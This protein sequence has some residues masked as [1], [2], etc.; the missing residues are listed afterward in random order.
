[1]ATVVVAR[2]AGAQP[3][4]QAS[5][6]ISLAEILSAL[7]FALDLTEGAVPGHALRSCLLGMRLGKELG[8]DSSRMASLYYALLLKDVGCSSNAARLCQII[9]GGDERRVK[10][11]VK[12]EDWTQPSKPKASTFKLLW[13]TVLPNGN[14]IERAAAIAHIGLTQHRNNK[15]IITLR[16]DRGAHILRK[17]GL[18]DIAAEAVRGL[19]EHWDG[20]GY[21]DSRT[22][23]DIPIESR[24]LAVAQHL[25]VFAT[26]EG[27]GK[28]I[29]VLR[30]RSGRWYDPEIVRIAS[31][32]HAGYKLWWSALS[33]TPEQETRSR[34]LEL[35]PEQVNQ[36]EASDIDLICQAFADVVDA[37]SSFTYRHSMGVTE[38]AVAIAC[39]LNLSSDRVRLVHRAALLHD[40]GKLSVPNSILDKQG[41]LD[42]NE[43]QIVQGHPRLTREIL[44]RIRQ[45]GRLALIAGAH[46]EKL[47][48]SG[49]PDH[50]MGS[51]LPL[52]ARIIAV[53]DVYGALTEDRPY[54]AGLPIEQ[55]VEIMSKDIPTRLDPDCYEALMRSL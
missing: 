17:L 35:A 7:S 28:A 44:S 34:V 5:G 49:Y 12:L 51:S 45:F 30:E 38:A 23:H 47:D 42:A 2:N 13:E 22:R 9:G 1:M 29:E 26:E 52:E 18:G 8:L 14:A 3:E 19:D 27:T 24:I 33:E 6:A 37:K 55:V 16:C 48:G 40:L 32:L 21:P 54:R 50:L 31:S 43:W 15:E 41:K 10:A 20:S 39:K 4:R 11:G 46:H 25:D 36:L 53:A